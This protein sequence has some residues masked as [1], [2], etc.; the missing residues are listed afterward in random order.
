[1][2][3]ATL[4][5]FLF[6]TLGLAGSSPWVAAWATS[7]QSAGNGEPEFSLGGQIIRQIVHMWVGGDELRVRISNEYWKIPLQIG[8]AS[9]GLEES[10]PNLKETS[11]SDLTFRSRGAVTI[12]AG[13]AVW[14]DP[15]K[16]PSWTVQPGSNLAITLYLSKHFDCTTAHKLRIQTNYVR[17]GDRSW[18][19]AARWPRADNAPSCFVTGVDVKTERSMRVIVGFGDSLTDGDKS[20]K[21]A[22]MRWTD[23]LSRCANSSERRSA[24]VINEGIAGARLIYD[25]SR[26]SSGLGKPAA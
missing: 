16:V 23:A 15:I 19:K 12:P 17:A 6:P 1:M 11:I 21:D 14:S 9:A 4:V 3:L 8:A 20:T 25:G 22:N 13:K 7:P 26:I 24:S 2:M 10:G 18:T 5:L